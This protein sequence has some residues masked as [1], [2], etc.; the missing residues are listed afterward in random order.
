MSGQSIRPHPLSAGLH[1]AMDEIHN[2][3][4][5]KAAWDAEQ[6][7]RSKRILTIRAYEAYVVN[8]LVDLSER[9]RPVDAWLFFQ[10]WVSV[11]L[12]IEDREKL[13]AT[14]PTFTIPDR[15][16]RKRWGRL[17]NL[18]VN[19]ALTDM[20]PHVETLIQTAMIE[21][22]AVAYPDAIPQ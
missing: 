6:A 13:Q 3:P 9:D 22:M 14:L 15:D 10:N 19:R 18:Y 12:G 16:L 20:Q 8:H 21:R 5:R 11:F 4:A 2:G 7:E 17:V 1:H